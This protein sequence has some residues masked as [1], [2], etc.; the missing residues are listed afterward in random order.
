MDSISLKQNRPVAIWL[1][2]GAVMIIV[3]VL[4]GGI[5]R[6]TGSGLSITEWQPILGALPP[7][8]EKAWLE[9]FEKYQQIAQY[10]YINSHFTLEDF[11]S[12]Y[13]WEWFHR[14]WGRLMGLVFIFP[15]IYFLVKKKI[16]RSMIHP[17]IILFLLG[18]LQGIIGW[19]MV[20]SGIGTDLVYVSHIRLAI[21]FMAALVL[22]CYVV[23]FAMKITVPPQVLSSNASVR[24]LNVW[25]LVLITIQ[26]IYGAFMA[27]T[28][29]ALAAPTWPT[30]N[31]MWW[32]GQYMFNQGSFIS[33][34]THNLISI[35]FIHRNLAYLIT[36]MLAWWTWKAS[37]LPAGEPLHNMR[38]IPLVLVVVQVVLGVIALLHSPLETKLLYS[39]LHQFVGILLLIALTVTYY[40]S[41]GRRGQRSR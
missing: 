1:L 26:L 7:M 14:D 12:I 9:A 27:G 29:A 23:W 34:I 21:H 31:G 40:Y 38:Y 19:V 18:G 32:P 41:R 33:D 13:F 11:K 25:L 20:K 6:L 17:M 36:I 10:K 15:F 39:I 4:L 35:Q 16:N 28:H 22:L 24:S 8:N 37:K 30:I 3:Q 5:T 2:I